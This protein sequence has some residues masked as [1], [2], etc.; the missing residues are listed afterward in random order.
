MV[1]AEPLYIALQ[2]AG[3]EGDA[4]RLVSDELVGSATRNER[5]LVDELLARA[6]TDHQLEKFVG[7]I[8]KETLEMLVD[9]EKYL[10]K[11]EEKAVEAADRAESYLNQ[12]LK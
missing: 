4:H 11:S 7:R 1:L 9:P 12:R 8:P 10:G 3:Y 5:G 2:M 6:K